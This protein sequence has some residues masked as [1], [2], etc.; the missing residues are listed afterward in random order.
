MGT[1]GQRAVLLVVIVAGCSSDV[2]VPALN[3]LVQR[4]IENGVLV[5]PAN[6]AIRIRVDS[7]FD[8]VG[9]QRFVLRDN[10]DAEQHVFVRVDEAGSLEALFWFQFEGFLPHAEGS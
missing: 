10:V 7:S 6:P 2:G 3:L 1:T 8:Y 9:G 4:Q 5:S